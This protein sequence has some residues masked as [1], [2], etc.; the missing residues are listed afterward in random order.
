M[1]TSHPMHLRH[2]TVAKKWFATINS[3]KTEFTVNMSIELTFEKFRPWVSK[4]WYLTQEHN[5]SKLKLILMSYSKFSLLRISSWHELQDIICT[6]SLQRRL[7][8][9]IS[10]KVS[11]T[12]IFT[13]NSVLREILSRHEMSSAITSAPTFSHDTSKFLKS[14]LYIHII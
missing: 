8:H 11:S 7:A 13:V 1:K 6:E 2:P 3:Q 10:Q 12:L 14:Q 5:F 4:Y 9:K